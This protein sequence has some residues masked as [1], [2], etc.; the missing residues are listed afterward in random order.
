MNRNITD[1]FF[2]IAPLLILLFIYKSN[3]TEDFGFHNDFAIWAGGDKCCLQ[4]VEA[5]HLIN[6]GRFI[7]A[8]LQGILIYFLDDISDLKYARLLSI[9]HQYINYLLLYKILRKVKFSLPEASVLSVS[10]FLLIPSFIN[11]SWVTNYIPGI[12]NL[13]VVL[14]SALFYFEA[15]NN[16][17]NLRNINLLLSFIF[18]LSFSIRLI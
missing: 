2:L 9:I 3:V 18:L 6:I 12:F 10:A 15:Q 4:F 17:F 16:R 1:K 7:Q 11:L 14:I 13:S 5:N 8:Y